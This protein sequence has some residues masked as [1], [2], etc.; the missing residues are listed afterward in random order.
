[1]NNPISSKDKTII[2]S[3]KRKQIEAS[4]PTKS[5]WVNASAGTGKTK[6]LVQRVLRLLLPKLN[7]KKGTRPDKVLC[8]TY[9]NAAA[10]EMEDRLLKAVQVWATC[11]DETLHENLNS[12]QGHPPTQEQ[13]KAARSL[14]TTLTDGPYYV[15]LLTIHSFCQSILGRFP[16]EAGITPHFNLIDDSQYADLIN[17]AFRRTVSDFLQDKNLSPFYEHIT[18]I[19]ADETLFTLV[20]SFISKKSDFLFALRNIKNN[21]WKSAFFFYFGL[22]SDF[23]QSHIDDEIS[24]PQASSLK[25]L[26]EF[27]DKIGHL[28]PAQD[29]Q[30]Q[31]YLYI[32]SIPEERIL[33][34]PS[35]KKSFY[36]KSGPKK[37]FNQSKNPDIQEAYEECI[38]FVESISKKESIIQLIET[39]F[40]LLKFI[41]HFLDH[42]S[43]IKQ[44][45]NLLDYDDLISKTYDL[46]AP[47][48]DKSTPK[49]WIMYKLDGGID[50]IL[51]D[52]AQDTNPSQWAIIRAL[53]DNFQSQDDQDIQKTIF[54]VGDQKQSIYRFQGADTKEFLLSQ[55]N[56][57]S[58][59]D[60]SVLDRVEMNIS[61]RSAA[62]ILDFVDTIF[63]NVHYQKALHLPS[64]TKHFSSREK[65]YGCVTLL[66]PIPIQEETK[67]D[68]TEW[69][70]SDD[71]YTD[72]DVLLSDQIAEYVQYLMTDGPILSSSGM[73]ARPKD[74]IILLLKRSRMMGHLIAALRK[75]GVPV[76]GMDRININD[77][78]SVQDCLSAA[79]AALLPEDN[80][81]LACFLKSPFVGLDDH[82]ILTINRKEGSSLYR[83]LV[84]DEKYKDISIYISKI[85]EIKNENPYTFF[86]TIL[87]MKVPGKIGM[88]GLHALQIRL[89][90]HIQDMIDELLMQALEASGNG[91]SLQRFLFDLSIQNTDKKREFH[92]D[93][94]IVR[95]M[96]VHGSKGLE[97][98]VV[99]LADCI[100][101]KRQKSDFGIFWPDDTGAPLPIWAPNKDTRT[102]ELEKVYDC[103]KESNQHEYMRLLYVALTRARDHLIIT[104]ADSKDA[105]PESWYFIVKKTFDQLDTHTGYQEIIYRDKTVLCF[106][107]R[108]TSTV[109]PPQNI[110]SSISTQINPPP[111]LFTSI[112]EDQLP[113]RPLRPIR[114]SA[115]LSSLSPLDSLNDPSRFRRGNIIHKLLQFIPDID[116]KDR[117]FSI[118]RY[119][120]VQSDLS[121]DDRAIIQDELMAIFTKPELS[122]LFGPGSKAEVPITGQLSDETYISGQV[123]RLWIGKDSIWIVDYKTNRPPPHK[124]ADVPKGYQDQLRAYRDLIQRIYPQHAVHCALLWTYGP[125]FMVAPTNF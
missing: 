86:S 125:Q 15:Q 107:N 66:P 48:S 63:S 75:K 2:D 80:Y 53:S 17:E 106:D 37:S 36:T 110:T 40:S 64:G 54:I 46:L 99:I 72:Q 8:L 18:S 42:L 21:E 3:A 87:Q 105:N 7:G 113:H 25:I 69:R 73:R 77:D 85:L 5:V 6:V 12:L 121:S 122:L 50:H 118:T 23:N 39:N 47:F 55:Q 120:S 44:H 94:D 51:V 57:S 124:W 71:F 74:I 41:S 24:H 29:L 98:P 11:D 83:S 35:F 123:D 10:A 103:L 115:H 31:I 93:D 16:I 76:G 79:H 45:K 52:E 60:S 81:S 108:Y 27:A 91:C 112:Q 43:S 88:S 67:K 100:H 34:W 84:S 38:S 89:G 117:P 56:F 4:D 33:L 68:K 70:I 65:A 13:I 97:A 61:F 59:S 109:I 32:S 78:L 82:D 30:N 62:P 104:G 90:T 101:S 111:Y 28:K 102:D 92:A 14:F 26:K 58:Y 96:T 95:L 9:T 119:L 20:K 49:N 1:M 22:P 116:E 19:S 114:A